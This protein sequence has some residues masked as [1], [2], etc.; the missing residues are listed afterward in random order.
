MMNRMTLQ[1]MQSV[2]LDIMKHV[3]AFCEEHGIKYSLG[4]GSLIGA[5][6]HKGFIPWD[7]DV[8]IVMMREDF[9]RFCQIFQDTPDFK[10]FSFSRGNMYATCARVCDMKRTLVET[11]SPLF[12]EPTGLWIDV[13]PLDSVDDDY[14][15]FLSK[16][17]RITDIQNKVFLARSLRKRLRLRDI[18][19]PRTFIRRALN[20]LK[21]GQ[22]NLWDLVR[23][24]DSLCRSFAPSDSR[25]M[26]MLVFPTYINKEF[27]PKH[28]FSEV[29][30]APFEDTSF[31]IMKGYDEWL[32]II[33]G[34]YMTPPS[35]NK[36]K[37]GHIVHKY[38]WR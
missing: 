15:V 30:D 35:D 16:I 34:D 8:D 5:V 13:F 14:D 29:I 25:M 24:Q 21:R 2:S 19:H 11:G 4:Y 18:S 27:T 28:V 7:D 23:K 26:S 20:Y 3:H 9:D 36:S 31:K 38:Y 1:E 17:N 12:T 37:R 22:Y 6:R 32:T 10:L 33:Y